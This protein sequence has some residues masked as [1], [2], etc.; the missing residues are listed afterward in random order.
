MRKMA[1]SE[2]SEKLY[3]SSGVTR[4]RLS[5]QVKESQ[6]LRLNSDKGS[7]SRHSQLSLETGD[8]AGRQMELYKSLARR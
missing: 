7:A 3:S 1:K 6:L 2:A 8:K 5:R 4:L